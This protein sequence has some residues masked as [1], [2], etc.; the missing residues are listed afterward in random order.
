MT[1]A[2][3]RSRGEH[4][5]SFVADGFEEGSSP[6]ARGAP[7]AWRSSC[8]RAGLI[9]ARA[10]STLYSSSWFLS[11]W[12][13]PR[14]RGEHMKSTM[15]AI[16]V[17]G[18][19]PLARGAHARSGGRRPPRGLIPARAG[20]TTVRPRPTIFS[21]AHPRSRGEHPVRWQAQARVRGSSPLARGAPGVDVGNSRAQGLIPARAGS[22]AGARCLYHGTWAHPRSR[23]EH[24]RTCSLLCASFGS[25]PLARGA[26]STHGNHLPSPGLIPARAGSTLFL[27]AACSLAGAHPRSRGEHHLRFLQSS[28]VP[29]SSPLARGA[30]LLT[31]GFTP[32]ISKIESL[33]SQSLY[34]EYTINSYS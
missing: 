34:P 23:G 14:S 19:S 1:G 30:H 17:L 3:P 15:L 28:G 21:R 20:S 6:L 16:I 33:W 27:G 31:W 2:H 5:G 13:H 24:Q 12:A 29:G 9:P 26:L 7:I 25:S 10:G 22:T 18:S 4:G 11:S 8:A 32:Y